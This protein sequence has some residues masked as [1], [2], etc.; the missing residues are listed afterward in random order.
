MKLLDQLVDER[1]EI[2][3][4]MAAVCDA[5]AEETR[6]LSETEEK[7]LSDLHTRADTLDVRITELRDIQL[8]NAEAAKM[9]AE[10]TPTQDAADAST[11]VRVGDETSSTVPPAQP[12][13]L[14]VWWYLSTWCSSPPS[15]RVQ[16]GRS[17]TCAPRCRFRTTV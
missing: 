12:G 13:T 10:V 8:A 3:T 6:D 17:P 11:E 16:A 9:R 5:A 7:N 14:P 4:S 15:W 1:A 2:G